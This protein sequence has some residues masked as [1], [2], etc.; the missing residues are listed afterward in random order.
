MIEKDGKQVR[1]V[2]NAFYGMAVEEGRNKNFVIPMAY[3][4][5]H[6]RMPDAPGQSFSPVKRWITLSGKPQPFVKPAFDSFKPQI[7]SILKRYLDKAIK[8]SGGKR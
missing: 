3:L 6:K 7:S 5:Q 8:K 2:V 4:E 1:V